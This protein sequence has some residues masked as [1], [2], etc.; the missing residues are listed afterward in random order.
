MGQA[1]GQEHGPRGPLAVLCIM[2]LPPA[3]HVT[4]AE[5][6][7]SQG[8][9]SP[10]TNGDD[11]APRV[12]HGDQVRGHRQHA[13][14]TAVPTTAGPER[15]VAYP[16]GVRASPRP[17]QAARPPPGQ[18]SNSS[19]SCGHP[20][21]DRLVSSRAV[22]S[23]TLWARQAPTRGEGG[24]E[25]GAELRDPGKWTQGGPQELSGVVPSPREPLLPPE[26]PQPLFQG[27]GKGP[28]PQGWGG[29]S[30]TGRLPRGKPAGLPSAAGTR[31]WL[32][33]GSAFRWPVTGRVSWT[34]D[35]M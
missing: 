16:P 3:S 18:S 6:S 4:H 35:W 25:L 22:C 10:N 24:H 7:S 26:T 8:L 1:R 30:I 13:R 29:K 11:S 2:A 5:F 33:H 20:G 15:G 23:L 17:E 31:R 14:P 28:P 27:E 34:G 9:S 32:G 19:F 21:T 12:C